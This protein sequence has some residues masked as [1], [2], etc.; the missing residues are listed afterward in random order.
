VANLANLAEASLAAAPSAASRANPAG[1][2]VP[3]ST[4]GPP[5]QALPAANLAQ[6]AEASQ[7]APSAENMVG[8]TAAAAAAPLRR[9]WTRTLIIMDTGCIC[10]IPVAVGLLLP[11]AAV[12]L[13]RPAGMV[14]GMTGGA[15]I[16]GPPPPPPPVLRLRP[17]ASLERLASPEVVR[18]ARADI[19]A[20]APPPPAGIMSAIMAGG[21][22]IT[23]GT[24]LLTAGA[25]QMVTTCG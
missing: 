16:T 8:L 25:L 17:A 9:L 22:D 6:L 12:L 13:F 1:S 5:P 14:D 7:A 18:V 19:P 20:L 2:V 10:N 3:P 15:I 21:A 23:G 24:H 11:P 4:D